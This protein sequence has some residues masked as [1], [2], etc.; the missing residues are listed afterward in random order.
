MPTTPPEP[1]ALP[2]IERSLWDPTQS[3]P[4]AREYGGNCRYMGKNND[5]YDI[6]RYDKN[7]L[8]FELLSN[9]SYVQFMHRM[10]AY[11]IIFY[12]VLVY[13]FYFRKITY[14]KPFKSIFVAIFIQVLLG[15]F[16]LISGLNIYLAS[17]HQIGSILLISSAIYTLFYVNNY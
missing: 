17:F 8:S 15:I 1:N 12:T 7:V 6:Y 11:F 2:V 10:L 9:P 5:I 3:D 16:T 4:S 13:F 14:S